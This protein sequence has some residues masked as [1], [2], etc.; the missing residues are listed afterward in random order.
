MSAEE[1]SFYEG[2]TEGVIGS[3]SIL[4][5]LLVDYAIMPTETAQKCAE[6]FE[7]GYLFG[8]QITGEDAL[9]VIRGY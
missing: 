3:L 5:E 7:Y 2:L 1:Y 6:A 4:E 9:E 8:M